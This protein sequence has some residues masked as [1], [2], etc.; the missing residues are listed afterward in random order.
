MN[1]YFFSV[2]SLLSCLFYLFCAFPVNAHQLSTSYIN[3]EYLEES[4]QYSGTWQIKIS[5]LEQRTTFDLNEDTLISWS[6]ITAKT[7]TIDTFVKENIVVKQNNNQCLFQKN[8][9]YQLDHH[10]NDPYLVVPITFNCLSDNTIELSYKAFFDNDEN[11]KAI[12]SLNKVNRVFTKNNGVQLLDIKTSSYF[13]TFTQ[14]VYQGILHI[15]MGLDHV[16]FVMT[17]LLT[18]VLIRN[19]GDWQGINS[20]LSIVK[21]TAWIVTA[22]TIAHSLTLTA[23]A[24][25]ILS[26]NTRWIE[27][28]IALSVLLTALNNIWPIVLKL[29]WITF[30]FGLLHGM[31]FASVL[32]ELGLSTDYQ[33]L[34]IL[35][36][37]LGVE[38]GQLA[39]VLFSL[40]IL[41]YVRHFVWYKKWIMPI[42][43]LVIA[44]VA[45]VWCFERF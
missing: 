28:G 18:A 17:L 32:S 31:G 44:A 9:G 23:T 22:F 41:I 6:E 4:Y 35:A 45:L 16:L 20:R 5:D 19:N 10:F 33:L 30:A 15:W 21:Q 14:Y 11:H 37:N 34:S 39:I 40:P 1:I 24:L 3:L 43:S 12:V 27:L 42:A 38:I 2:N 36:F 26:F 13:T 29:G 8:G 25:D 7:A